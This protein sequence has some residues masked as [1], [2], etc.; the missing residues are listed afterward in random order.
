MTTSAAT[1]TFT[2]DDFAGIIGRAVVLGTDGGA[3]GPN[4]TAIVAAVD[5]HILSLRVGKMGAQ[6]VR[7]TSITSLA[8]FP[9]APEGV[10]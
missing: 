3:I 1:R 10:R 8:V 2:A 4:G 9:P 5:S 7:L 6:N